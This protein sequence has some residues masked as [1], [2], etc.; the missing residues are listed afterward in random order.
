MLAV[1][2][3]CTSGT[4]VR[5]RTIVEQ[6]YRRG[7]CKD[8]RHNPT[9]RDVELTAPPPPRTKKYI[10]QTVAAQQRALCALLWSNRFGIQPETVRGVGR[11]LKTPTHEGRQR[12]LLC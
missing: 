4:Y 8:V 2:P 5:C 3:I 6:E 7:T 11:G 12:R 10:A 1:P 9:R